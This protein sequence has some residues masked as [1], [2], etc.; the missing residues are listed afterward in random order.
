MGGPN[1][2]LALFDGKPLVGRT[3]E[4]ALASSR[5]GE[6]VVITGHQDER[7]R[8]G[9]CRAR[10][11]ASPT[12]RDYQLGPV[13][14]AEGRHA[15]RFR[16]DAAGALIV[17]GDM[18]GVTAADLDRLIA[19]FAQVRRPAIVRATHDGK[20]GNP[21]ILPRALFPEIAKLEGDT[22]ARHLVEAQGNAGR[23]RRDRR[24]R[25]RR[26]RHARGDAAESAGGVLQD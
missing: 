2:L 9:A 1:K 5:A 10:R 8:G 7:V 19:A 25:Q 23:R 14:L 20:R 6:V 3:A 12:I 16:A 11:Q 24:R 15:R 13:E 4:T 17:L 26:R 18:P 21:V 22:G